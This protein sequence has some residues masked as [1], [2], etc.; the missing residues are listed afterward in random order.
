MSNIQFYRKKAGLTQGGLAELCGWSGSSRVGNYEAGIRTPG[1]EDLQSIRAALAKKKVRV[2]LEQL[3][4]NT[5][6]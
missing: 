1:V 6:A 2:T 3:I 5:A 4:G